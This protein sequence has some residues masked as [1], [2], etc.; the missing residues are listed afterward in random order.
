M[1]IFNLRRISSIKDI[2]LLEKWKGAEYSVNT[3]IDQ[4]S[5]IHNVAN[6]FKVF[7]IVT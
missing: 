5:A 6:T 1:T 4:V 2:F 3:E 7:A